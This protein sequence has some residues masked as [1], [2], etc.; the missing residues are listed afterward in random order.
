MFIGCNARLPFSVCFSAAR[1]KEP[2]R[3]YIHLAAGILARPQFGEGRAAEKQKEDFGGS[4][5]YKHR[6]PPGLR[7]RPVDNLKSRS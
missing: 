2:S 5:G 6:T 3:A 7:V 4:P 1:R